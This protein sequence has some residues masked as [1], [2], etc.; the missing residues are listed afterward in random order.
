MRVSLAMVDVKFDLWQ[1]HILRAIKLHLECIT[2]KQK[3]NSKLKDFIF[4]II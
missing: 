2:A 1:W 3:T 4:V